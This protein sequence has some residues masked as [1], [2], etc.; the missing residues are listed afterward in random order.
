MDKNKAIARYNNI[1]EKNLEQS[2]WDCKS[3]EQVYEEIKKKGI[4]IDPDESYEGSLSVHENIINADGKEKHSILESI[5]LSSDGLCGIEKIIQYSASVEEAK[6]NYK[7]IREGM[8]ECLIWPCHVQSINICRGFKYPFDDR[9]DLT[10]VDIQSFYEKI[11]R[12][13]NLSVSLINDIK[14]DNENCLL[15]RAYLNL[16]TFTWLCSFDDFNSF[17]KERKLGA[18]VNET[19]GEFKAKQWTD[20]KKFDDKYFKKLIIRTQKYRAQNNIDYNTK[21]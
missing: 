19:N 11:N 6:E 9:I 14:N 13:K 12:K 7:L 16:M 18:F 8:F 4:Y 5:S 2:F 17:I 20:T 3:K 21:V 10:L 15:H 1:V